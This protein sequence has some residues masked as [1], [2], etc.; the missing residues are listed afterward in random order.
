MDDT[1]ALSFPKATTK[2]ITN[3][4]I[5]L[6]NTEK[7]WLAKNSRLVM[8]VGV[9]HDSVEFIDLDRLVQATHVTA[10]EKV[11]CFAR[12]YSTRSFE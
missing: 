5:L 9:P 2:K 11:H 12:T 8:Y 3:V 4:N 7:D 10:L 6:V 1:Y